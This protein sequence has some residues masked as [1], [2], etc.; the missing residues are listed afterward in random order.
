M[1]G[2]M[3]LLV[4]LLVVDKVFNLV[5]AVLAHSHNPGN[6]SNPIIYISIYI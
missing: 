1:I 3:L 4:V 6:N 2:I 5:T